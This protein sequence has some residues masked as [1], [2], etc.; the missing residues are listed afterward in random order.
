MT[1]RRSPGADAPQGDVV[2][3]VPAPVEPV[4]SAPRGAKPSAR[5]TAPWAAAWQVWGCYRDA[6]LDGERWPM[7]SR[8]EIFR[9]GLEPERAIRGV[10]N[11]VAV[12]MNPGGS[13][14][15]SE[16]DPRGWCLAWPDRT[17][18]Q[19][20]RLADRLAV[21]GVR[22]DHLRVLNLSDLRTPRSA[23]LMAWLD[24]LSTDRHSL[25]SEARASECRDALGPATVPVLAAWGLG[26][27]LRPWARQALQTLDG[28]TVLGL[29]VDGVGYR[30]PLPKRF[31]LQQAWLTAAEHLLVTAL[32]PTGRAAGPRR[33]G[34]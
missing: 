30:H 1:R 9:R 26:A 13:R 34:V 8:L 24:R 2:A 16:P 32:R 6:L 14:P 25:F 12:M 19:L 18:H 33:P 10:P 29:T 4:R 22:W 21:H 28:R 31:D 23:E 7:R 11:V 27:R 5:A 17:Q 20:M 15:L 3:P